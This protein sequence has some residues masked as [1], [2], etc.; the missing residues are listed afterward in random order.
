VQAGIAVAVA[1]GN[2]GADAC[3]Y[4]P[5]RAPAAM[6]VGATNSSDTRPSFSN[7]GDCV[8]WFAPGV[9]ITS[10]SSAGDGS[11]SIK[12]GTSMASPHT[13]GAAALYLEL[14]PAATPA[15]VASALAAAATKD[16]VKSSFSSVRDLLQVSAIAAPDSSNPGGGNL[17]PSA[18]F[19]YACTSLTCAFTDLS[20]DAD[21][22]VTQWT[23][24]FGDSSGAN[25]RDP[26]HTY[27][28][29]GTY[30]VTLTVTDNGGHTSATSR[31]LSVAPPA[32]PANLSPA[33]SFQASCAGL[34][35]TFTDTSS[36]PDGSIMEWVW[37]FG[38]GASSTG[39]TASTL[40]HTFGGG[41]RYG[42]R[43]TVSDD[44]GASATTVQE[45]S[46]GIVLEVVGF[47]IKGRHAADLA[48]TGATSTDVRIFVNR[49]LHA[50]VANT[51]RYEFRTSNKGQGEYLL[52]V[53]ETGANAPCTKEITIR[54]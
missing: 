22:S 3:L 13:A 50:T 51:G 43:L 35:C 34:T 52:Q 14:D 42:V 5:A 7:W 6:T 25:A 47:R 11:Y 39:Q 32:A 48:W 15:R 36:D 8:D 24:S 40:S 30:L 19:T 23:W 29:D 45:V 44:D 17:P 37:D 49:V 53:C 21:G 4:S 12:S 16:V 33:A 9:S 28:T 54:P 10:A 2:S 20:S 38:D 31:S 26:A 18:G 41:G 46:V 1:A 27:S